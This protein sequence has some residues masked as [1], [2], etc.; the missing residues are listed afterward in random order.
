MD[1]NQE[2]GIAIDIIK[3]VARRTVLWIFGVAAG[4]AWVFSLFR[5]GPLVRLGL[6]MVAFGF[7]ASVYGAVREVSIQLRR[8]DQHQA[9]RDRLGMHWQAL[10][11]LNLEYERRQMTSRR[12]DDTELIDFMHR[13]VAAWTG[14]RRDVA[15][16]V[17]RGVGAP[18]DRSF[19]FTELQSMQRRDFEARLS[20]AV[21]TLEQAVRAAQ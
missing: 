13:A 14:V 6:A 12:G 10:N 21:A 9:G 19:S 4:V 5:E 3:S 18:F 7:V 16:Q 8:Q 11:A 1:W 2:V 17:I 15:S 20:S